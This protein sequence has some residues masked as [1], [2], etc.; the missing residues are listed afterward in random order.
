MILTHFAYFSTQ[1]S[2][3]AKSDA[4]RLHF[5]EF[6][7]LMHSNLQ[8]YA[9]FTISIALAV[10]YSDC[11]YCLPF[12]LHL[13]LTIFRLHLLFTIPVCICHYCTKSNSVKSEKIKRKASDFAG[14]FA[15]LL[16]I[17][18]IYI[19]RPKGAVREANLLLQVH[20]TAF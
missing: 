4:L 16:I 12:R 11:T 5:A 10:F 14:R 1:E 2:R 7:N 6:H 13:L 20:H 8:L 9:L 15:W 17:L 3:H 19:Q 18:T